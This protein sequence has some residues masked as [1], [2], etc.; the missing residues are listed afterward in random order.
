[1]PCSPV[2]NL[3]NLDD[4]NDDRH[5][6]SNDDNDCRASS[7]D[8]DNNP[9]LTQPP[10]LRNTTHDAERVPFLDSVRRVIDNES[11][12]NFS[13][14]VDYTPP[15]PPSIVIPDYV[16][17][18]IRNELLVMWGCEQPQ[19]YQIEAIFHLVYRKTDMMYLTRRLAKVNH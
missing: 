1:M 19:S 18:A 15:M 4:N 2:D 14:E 3:N 16:S 13:N 10:S 7:E 8:D 11:D 17:S 12:F 5:V 6:S 9:L